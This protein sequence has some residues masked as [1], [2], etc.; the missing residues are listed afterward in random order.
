[1]NW[2]ALYC[3]P[4]HEKTVETGLLA[5][6]VGCFYPSY[7]ESSRWSDRRK[8]VER[9]LFPGYVFARFAAGSAEEYAARQVRGCLG[10]LGTYTG[11]IPIADSEIA[12]IQQLLA[13]GV[14]MHAEP[15]HEFRAGDTVE[16]AYGPFVGL[17]GVIERRKKGTRLIVAITA[18]RMAQ[19][20]E[21]DAESL[22]AV[23]EAA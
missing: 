11:P 8:Q 22:R 10:V 15:F 16:I 1:M 12:A 3:R 7:F 17:R 20:I 19:S 21:L 5:E 2:Y 23:R 13:L 6:H 4:Q 18:I 9:P 14:P